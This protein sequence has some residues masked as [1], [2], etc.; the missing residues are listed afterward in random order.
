MYLDLSR[1]CPTLNKLTVC[2][3]QRPARGQ[4]NG[5]DLERESVGLNRR[6]MEGGTPQGGVKQRL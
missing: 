6:D 3:N 1:Q 5:I 2:L 4:Q